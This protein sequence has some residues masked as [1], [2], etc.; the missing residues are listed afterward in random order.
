MNLLLPSTGRR[1]SLIK[2]LRNAAKNLNIDLKIIGTECNPKTP[3]LHFC[4]HFEIVPR[5]DDPKFPDLLNQLLEHYKID[6]VLPGSDLDLKYFLN[7]PLKEGIRVLD[8]GKSMEIF[9]SKS[10]SALF[11]EENGLKIPAIYD[12]GQ[13]KSF[14]CVLKEDMGYGSV[15]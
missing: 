14:P 12:Y 5:M 4:D 13:I 8:S 2:R 6:F 7:H 9:L 3:S 10:K 1:V 11:F 15:N